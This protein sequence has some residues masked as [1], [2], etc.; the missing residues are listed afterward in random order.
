M[1]LSETD[2]RWLGVARAPVRL[3]LFAAGMASVVPLLAWLYG[4]SSFGGSFVAVAVLGVPVLAAGVVF[5]TPSERRVLGVAVVA[6]VLGT[7][8]YDLFRVPFAVIGGYR[9]FAP[10]AS[11]GVLITGADTSTPWT[12]LAGWMYHFLNGLGFAVAYAAVAAG[13]HWGCGVAWGLCLET[14]T[15]LTP[16]AT[17]YGLR[18]Q[19]DAITIAYAAHVPYGF[20]VG[21]LLQRPLAAATEMRRVAPRPGLTAVILLCSSVILWLSPW[22]GRDQ[23]VP[24]GGGGLVVSGRMHPEYVRAE[25]D[26]CV[27]LINAD[28]TT[29]DVIAKDATGQ[30]ERSRMARICFSRAGV[31]RLR[32]DDQPYSGGFVIVDAG[33][34]RRGKLEG[35]TQ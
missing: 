34:A 35:G 12:E 22:R 30:L 2:G 25:R 15:L 5:A 33:A 23:A 26:G 20:V 8:A 27:R 28:A 19:Y 21:A 32:L 10:I 17:G 18:G 31:H 14:G 29:Y 16:F 6:G 3:A 4:V 11:Y 1:P 7:V 13:R 9:L 24:A